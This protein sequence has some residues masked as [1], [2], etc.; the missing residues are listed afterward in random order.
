MITDGKPD[1]STK[2][3]L[4]EIRRINAHRNLIINVISFNC[5]DKSANYFLSQLASENH[6]RFHK[7]SKS[8]KDI[9]LFAHKILTEGIQDSYVSKAR[10]EKVMLIKNYAY[11]LIYLFSYLIYLTLREM[12]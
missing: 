1:N 4:D 9:H 11:I 5:D 8:D 12:I 6:G 10:R 3:V 2:L 7:T